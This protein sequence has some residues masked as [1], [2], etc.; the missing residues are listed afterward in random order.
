MGQHSDWHQRRPKRLPRLG[1]M[2]ALTGVACLELALWNPGKRQMR[3]KAETKGNQQAR[4]L[5]V[6]RVP[7]RRTLCQIPVL[8]LPS[9]PA[10]SR[11]QGGIK[12]TLW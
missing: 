2:H 11:A 4:H 12:P 1:D 6:H 5:A 7:V 8:R 3:H 9:G 10:L